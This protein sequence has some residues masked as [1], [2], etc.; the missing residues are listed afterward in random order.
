MVQLFQESFDIS[1]ELGL[2]LLAQLIGKLIQGLWKDDVSFVE[3]AGLITLLATIAFGRHL[4]SRL[5]LA[6]LLLHQWSREKV[7]CWGF[8]FVIEHSPKTLE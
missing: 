8:D 3:G 4:T 7:C 5:V 6:S 2:K 1:I